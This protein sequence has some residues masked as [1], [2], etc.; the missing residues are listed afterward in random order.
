MSEVDSYSRKLKQLGA[1]KWALSG[2]QLPCL[3]QQI[4]GSHSRTQIWEPDWYHQP[5]VIVQEVGLS[6]LPGMIV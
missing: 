6:G 3:Q 1:W 4:R 5:E 2:K